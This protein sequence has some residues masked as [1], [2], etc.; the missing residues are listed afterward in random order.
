M[1]ASSGGSSQTRRQAR[2]RAAAWLPDSKLKLTVYSSGE[3]GG[4]ACSAPKG[5]KTKGKTESQHVPILCVLETKK[6]NEPLQKNQSKQSLRGWPG[7]D[8]V[9]VAEEGVLGTR[10]FAFGAI[11]LSEGQLPARLGTHGSPL[12]V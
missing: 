7:F 10:L 3:E 6:A 11:P 9:T 8:A 12:E 5:R 2:H 1:A 4:P